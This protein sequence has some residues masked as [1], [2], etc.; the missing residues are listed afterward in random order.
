MLGGGLLYGPSAAAWLVT[1]ERAAATPTIS[2]FIRDFLWSGTQ[3]ALAVFSGGTCC[4]EAQ[5]QTIGTGL[6]SASPTC[7]REMQSNCKP[8]N[9]GPA[10]FK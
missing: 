10:L 8:D 9:I 2:F 7:V 5:R 6:G 1:K 3:H 4:R